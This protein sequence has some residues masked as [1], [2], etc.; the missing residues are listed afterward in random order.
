M[1]KGTT[2]SH[3]I[4]VCTEIF[5]RTAVPDILWT[6]GGPQ[7]TSRAFQ[8]YLHQWSI[9]HKKS[10]PHD[11]QSNSKVEATVKAMKKVLKTA[12]TGRFL[13]KS[14]LYQAL[15]QYHNTPSMRDG[16]S[17][18]QKLYGHFIHYTLPI[19]QQ[20]VKPHNQSKDRMRSLR[21]HSPYRSNKRSDHQCIEG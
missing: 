11:P 3:L 10:T 9:F 20:A 19:H 4:A 21:N 5:G 7:F 16:L 8:D 12:W 15:I 18:S 17:P 2:A 6:N 13:N 14:V 1:N